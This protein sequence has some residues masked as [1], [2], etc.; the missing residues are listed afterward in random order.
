VQPAADRS[1]CPWAESDPLYRHYHDHEWGIPQHDDQRLFEMLILEG[2]QAGLSWITILKKRENFRVAFAQWDWRKVSQFTEPDVARL[3]QDAG[4]IRNRL[5]IEA[6]IKNANAFIAIIDEF[7]S[8]DR[9]IWRFTGNTTLTAKKRASAIKD[10]P[11]HTPQSDAMSKDLRKRG[12]SFV[13][14]VICYSFMQAIG[15][16]DD[17]LAG[18]FRADQQANQ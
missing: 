4:I 7:G 17:H 2:F 15:M 14:S 12:F 18:C 11:T 10:L 8:F 9:Y 16:V 5:K 6:A 3:M 1:C 13:G